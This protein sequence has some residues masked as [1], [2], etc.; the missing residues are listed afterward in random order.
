MKTRLEELLFMKPVDLLVAIREGN[1]N[2]VSVSKSAKCCY[3]HVTLMLNQF[4]KQGFLNADMRGRVKVLTLTPK[5]AEVADNI[6]EI[7][8]ILQQGRGS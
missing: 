1:R 5:G 3:T 8:K 6:I 7:K 4:E 2:P